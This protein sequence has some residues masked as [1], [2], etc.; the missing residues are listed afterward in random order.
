VTAIRALRQEFVERYKDDIEYIRV[1]HKDADEARANGRPSS[2]VEAILARA[3]DAMA[4]VRRAELK[5]FEDIMKLLT[6]EQRAKWCIVRPR[7]LIG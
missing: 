6:P 1:V 3:K 7:G 2:V 5:L 4:R